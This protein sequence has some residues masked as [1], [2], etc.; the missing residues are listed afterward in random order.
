MNCHRAKRL[1]KYIDYRAGADSYRACTFT[2]PMKTKALTFII[3]V[4]GLQNSALAQEYAN[5][6]APDASAVFGGQAEEL[7]GN[8]GLSDE[9]AYTVQAPATVGNRKGFPP[10]TWGVQSY[11]GDRK[12]TA[13]VAREMRNVGPARRARVTFYNP[14]SKRAIEGGKHTRFSTDEKVH[15]IEMAIKTG[16]PVTVAAD[17]LNSFGDACNQTDSRCTLLFKMAGFD[18]KFPGYRKKFKYLPKN[19]FIAIVEDTGGAFVGTNGSRFDLSS[20]SSEL[21]F[22]IPS[23][24]NQYVTW[25]RLNTPCGMDEGARYCNYEMAYISEATKTALAGGGKN[26]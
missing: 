20:L 10:A 11:L 12:Y 8:W 15:S 14:S 5:P 13:I 3:V 25:V 2:H 23:Y 24:M 9:E 16:R 1:I 19:T 6:Y 4:L 17:Y 7:P 26:L 18:A 22:A 21:E